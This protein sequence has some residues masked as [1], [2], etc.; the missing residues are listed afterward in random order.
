MWDED[1]QG[2]ETFLSTIPTGS[3]I[4]KSETARCHAIH[5]VVPLAFILFFCVGSEIPTMEHRPFYARLTFSFDSRFI[6]SERSENGV[7]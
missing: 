4:E 7:E 3:V 6:R 5:T 1:S 2:W